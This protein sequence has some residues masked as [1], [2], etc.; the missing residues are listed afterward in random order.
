MSRRSDSCYG[1][2]NYLRKIDLDDFVSINHIA[3]KVNP[4]TSEELG[5]PDHGQVYTERGDL[6][7]LCIDGTLQDLER[8]RVVE[9]NNSANPPLYRIREEMLN[10]VDEFLATHGELNS[11]LLDLVGTAKDVLEEHMPRD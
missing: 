10:K 7:S 4:V 2:L 9:V 11:Q 5:E 1:V 3:T 8:M 6:R